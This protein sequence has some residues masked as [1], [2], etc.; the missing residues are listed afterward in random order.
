MVWH[1]CDKRRINLD[2]ESVSRVFSDSL[3]TP[4]VSVLSHVVIEK[5]P[6]TFARHA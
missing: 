2:C 3:F 1:A 5:P 4:Y 6:H